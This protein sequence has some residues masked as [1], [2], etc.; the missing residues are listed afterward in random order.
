MRAPACSITIPVA[1]Y[2]GAGD[3]YVNRFVNAGGTLSPGAPV[4]TM[5]FSAGKNFTNTILDI[6][7][8]GKTTPGTDFDNIGVAGLA[9]LG[10]SSI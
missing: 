9:T 8:N 7:L 6:E 3:I 4:G 2:K 1:F 5:S 10:G